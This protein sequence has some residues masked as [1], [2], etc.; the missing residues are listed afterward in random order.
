MSG[1]IA[2]GTEVHHAQFQR[3]IV[4]ADRHRG[5]EYLVRFGARERWIRAEALR[6]IERQTG[7]VTKRPK[8]PPPTLD[9]SGKRIYKGLFEAFRL[10]IVPHEHIEGWTFGR[11]DVVREIKDWLADQAFGSLVLEGAYG[12]GKTHLLEFLYAQAVLSGYAVAAIGFDPSESPAAFPKRVYR[13]VL[14]SLRVPFRGQSLTFREAFREA[15][16]APQGPLLGDH[17]LLGPMLELART[18]RMGEALWEELEGR[19]S[20]ST[21]LPMYDHTTTANLYCYLLSGLGQLF[22]LGL[23]AKGLVLLLDEVETAKSYEYAYQW[24]RSLNFFRG[25]SLVANDEHTLLDEAVE[26]RTDV[27]RGAETGLVYSGHNQAPY[28]YKIP[29]YLKVV[30]AITPGAFTTEFLRWHPEQPVLTL[31]P[32]GAGPL[33]ELFDRM[34][35]AYGQTWGTTLPPAERR[36]AFQA[37]TQRVELASTRILIKALVEILD[38]RRFHPGADLEDLLAHGR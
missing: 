14:S 35:D 22:T 30:F 31:D 38:F 2:R 13:R 15:A 4:I 16:Q 9:D 6:P 20:R 25:L 19:R 3:G 21:V 18:G 37:L 8:A 1:I 7:P 24:R 29:S 23:G 36:D 28:L 11:D 26:R 5:F 10:G 12:S 32:L 27:R 33:Y 34:C 17:T